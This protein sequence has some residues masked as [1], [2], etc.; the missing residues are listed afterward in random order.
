MVVF[1][2]T[3]L[4]LT[5]DKTYYARLEEF[6]AQLKGPREEKPPLFVDRVPEL[7]KLAYNA[8][9]VKRTV[10]DIKRRKTHYTALTYGSGKTT[11]GKWS[12]ENFFLKEDAIRT[13]LEEMYGYDDEGLDEIMKEAQS[14]LLCTVTLD[15]SHS[16]YQSTW[17]DYVMH[18]FYL[19]KLDAV[20]KMKL[21]RQLRQ[22]ACTMQ[23]KL[24]KRTQ[25]SSMYQCCREAKKTT[26]RNGG[27]KR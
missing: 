9:E 11:L 4:V 19:Q 3:S 1:I 23:S 27:I 22:V 26:F 17:N 6:V 15:S 21:L 8:Y 13:Q 20:Q 14:S 16:K 24:Y 10:T 5:A 7:A 12:L 2:C 25:G 18:V